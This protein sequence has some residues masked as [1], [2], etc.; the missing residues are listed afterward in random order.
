MSSLSVDFCCRWPPG[1]GG[2]PPWRRGTYGGSSRPG[3]PGPPCPRDRGGWPSGE[4]RCPSGGQGPCPIHMALL[5][6]GRGDH[7][8]PDDFL[9]CKPFL[10]ACI[11]LWGWVVVLAHEGAIVVKHSKTTKLAPIVREFVG[12]AV[13][14]LEGKSGAV[15]PMSRARPERDQRNHGEKKQKFHG[16]HLGCWRLLETLILTSGAGGRPNFL[17]EVTHCFLCQKSAGP[18]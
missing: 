17:E 11:F 8:E 12:L 16:F 1:R 9:A 14:S 5:A 18:Y 3:R 4:R 13:T 10:E 7:R 2:F 15:P 6:R